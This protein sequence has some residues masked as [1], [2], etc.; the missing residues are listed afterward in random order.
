MQNE[1]DFTGTEPQPAGE[2]TNGTASICLFDLTHYITIQQLWREN[3][4]R[5]HQN[6]FA[7]RHY[8]RSKPV[9]CSLVS[10]TPE[11]F[12]TIRL[13]DNVD[14]SNNIFKGDPVIFGKFGNSREVNVFGGFVLRKA[15]NSEVTISPDMT[16]YTVERRHSI[17]YPVS[18]LGYVK[19]GLF[20]EVSTPVLI[21]D[22]SYDGVRICTEASLEVGECLEINVCIFKNV[23]NI[24]GVVA[25]KRSLYGRNEYGVQMTFRYKNTIF[26][27]REYI[28]N[29]VNQEKRLLE[30][31]LLALL[32]PL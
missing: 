14:L 4:N 10:G 25:R 13:N 16:S 24:E 29:L 17:R 3:M 23:I 21:K 12:F 28:D 26:T 18:I 15:E 20:H 19:H 32:P 9:T 5:N 7:L 8:S 31:H 22:I 6:F 30:N 2:I 1:E 11:S 27:V